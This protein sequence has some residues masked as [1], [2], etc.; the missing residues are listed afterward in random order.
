[1]VSG[2]KTPKCPRHVRRSEQ[3]D[4]RSACSRG[5]T[6]VDRIIETEALGA[7]ESERAHLRR[8]AAIRLLKHERDPPRPCHPNRMVGA[9]VRRDGASGAV[10]LEIGDHNV[11]T[12]AT[13]E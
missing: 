2:V 13:L 5:E 12:A 6:I 1:M 8:S 9:F 4:D 7:F 11:R 3:G 10:R